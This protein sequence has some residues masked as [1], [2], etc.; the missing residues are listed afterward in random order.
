[1]FK[2]DKEMKNHTVTEKQILSTIQG[3]GIEKD[4]EQEVVNDIEKLIDKAY[5][6]GI[7]NGALEYEEDN[8]PINEEKIGVDFVVEKFADCKTLED[9]QDAYKWIFISHCNHMAI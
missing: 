2:E 7:V 6:E 5:D 8:P 3:Y 1:M 4:D 9:F